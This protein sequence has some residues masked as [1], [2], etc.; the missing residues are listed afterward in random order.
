MPPCRASGSTSRSTDPRFRAPSEFARVHA[1]VSPLLAGTDLAALDTEDVAL[2][3]EKTG[4]ARDHVGR[5]VVARRIAARAKLPAEAVYG[6]LRNGA[7]ASVARHLSQSPRAVERMLTRA[8]EANVVSLATGQQAGRVSQAMQTALAEETVISESPQSLGKLL[9]TA[10]IEEGQQRDLATRY[11]QRQGDLK[12]FWRGLRSDPAWGNEV[13]D[14]A[15]LSLQLGRITVNHPPLV[16][17]LLD[18]G[19]SSARDTAKLDRQ[20]WADLMATTV[21]GV[22]IGVPNGVKG[23]DEQERRATYAR[24]LARQVEMAFPTAAVAEAMR[25]QNGPGTRD[26]LTFLDQNSTFE[27][28]TTAVGSFLSAEGTD[29]GGV[30]DVAGLA[31]SL[32]AQQRLFRIAPETDK[33]TTMSALDAVGLDSA[34]SVQR[35]GRDA[36]VSRFSGALGGAAAARTVYG[37]AVAQSAAALNLLAIHSGS[38]QGVEVATVPSLAAETAGGVSELPDYRT[39]FGSIDFCECAHCRSVLGPAAY[40]VDLLAWLDAVAPTVGGTPGAVDELLRRRPDLGTVELSCDNTTIPFPYVDLINVILENAIAG[41][42]GLALIDHDATTVAAEELLAKPEHFNAPV[43][44]EVLARAYYPF[45][46]PFNLAGTQARVFL[47]ELGVDR[48]DLMETFQRAADPT[49]VQVATEYLK[50]STD[51]RDLITGTAEHEQWE[52]WGFAAET[53][54]PDPRGGAGTV[55]YRGALQYVPELLR[56]AGI[57]YTDLL[58]LLHT[59]FVNGDGD[60]RIVSTGVT[61]CNLL[62]ME[63]E[64]A[65]GTLP[66]G[67]QLGHMRRLVRL[68]RALGFT[69]LDLDKALVALTGAQE[70]EALTVRALADIGRIRKRV[71]IDLLS[72]LTWW[73]AIDLKEDRETAE[74]KAV[75]LYDQVFLN[76]AIIVDAATWPFTLNADRS[77]LAD[78]TR[79]ATPADAEL[80]AALGLDA[81]NLLD[82]EERVARDL[83]RAAGRPV[84]D[85]AAEVAALTLNLDVLTRL[86]RLATL[87]K[88]LK[89]SVADALAHADLTDIDPFEGPQSA[90]LFIE[91]VQ[92]IRKTGFSIG[93]LLYLLGHDAEAALEVAPSEDALAVTLSGLRSGLQ[94]IQDET[95]VEPDATGEITRQRLTPI[96]PAEDLDALMAVIAGGSLLSTTEQE[97]LIDEHLA[98]FLPAAVAKTV[99][100]TG[101]PASPPPERRYG[102]VLAGLIPYLAQLASEALVKEQIASALG[103]ELAA[104]ED[105]LVTRVTSGVRS[106]LGVFLA[107]PFVEGLPA[108]PGEEATSGVDPDLN[109]TDQKVAFD[110]LILLHKIAAVLKKLEVGASEQVWLFDHEDV[111]GTVRLADLPLEPTRAAD[112]YPGWRAL[113]ELVAARDRLPGTEPELWE[114]LDILLDYDAADAGSADAAR[115]TFLTELALRTGWAVTDLEHVTGTFLLTDPA[116]LATGESLLRVIDAMALVTR[117]GTTADQVD[118]WRA[119]DLTVSQAADVVMA[120]KSHHD[121]LRW[122]QVARPLTGRAEGAAARRPGLLA[123]AR[124][125][126]RGRE[127]P[128]CRIP[129]RRADESL[130]AHLPHHAGDLLG[131]ALHPAMLPEPGAGARVDGGDLPHRGGRRALGVDED[132]PGLG[133]QPQGVPASGELDRARAPRRQDGDLPAARERADAG[134]DHRR[135]RWRPPTSGIWND[136]FRS[137]GS[138]SW[139]SITRRRPMTMAS[140]RTCSTCSGARG[141]TP[142]STTTGPGGTGPSGPRGRSSSWTSRAITCSPWSTSGA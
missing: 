129:D 105:L 88:A 135:R 73:S 134:R 56:R 10:G 42:N 51:E 82:A 126:L 128:V 30:T 25:R 80:Q 46:L 22:P 7:P 50:L 64:R 117:I 47:R 84:T 2:V 118:S 58:D 110:V 55:G 104:A 81:E 38:F 106:A 41:L 49:D 76:H 35:M 93:D 19:I 14:R 115:G 94:R 44:E 65:D 86:Y 9:A 122:P 43:Y 27:F 59:D 107:N 13:V 103:L 53:G 63:L 66:T 21:D 31:A 72:L 60:L 111:L 48:W 26:V 109:P 71:K 68:R 67:E 40:F 52:L 39:L 112:R 114:L 6:L 92:A 83:A 141:A 121:A 142:T 37:N 54:V 95:V 75:P 89:L 96:V 45:D 137:R 139:R 140:S 138:R 62:E 28:G 85:I 131:P 57:E 70:I 124:E 79:L 12:E 120:V 127:R 18:R 87:A 23:A 61:A 33:Y 100:I 32:R 136:C 97:A 119:A 20:D 101:D 102:F 90:R 36:F 24:V 17:A 34:L 1:T 69:M 78:V 77:E 16:K 3:V 123:R 11:L 8:A 108:T 98:A 5:Y 74:P 133:G 91:E 116:T 99:L 113:A 15:Q 29:L 130:H 125:G 4:L 132:L